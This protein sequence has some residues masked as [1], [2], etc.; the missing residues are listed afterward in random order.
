MD[1]YRVDQG[2]ALEGRGLL[3][4][5]AFM[6]KPTSSFSLQDTSPVVYDGKRFGRG[7]SL[8]LSQ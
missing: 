4:F 2:F 3:C 6:I 1:R 7:A 8:F 5:Y